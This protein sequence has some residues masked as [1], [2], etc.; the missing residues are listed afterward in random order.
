M[1]NYCGECEEN[2]VMK[3]FKA[4]E[5]YEDFLSGG[6]KV[7]LRISKA[8]STNKKLIIADEPT[9]NLD[10]KS[11]KILEARL[12]KMGGQ[13]AKKILIII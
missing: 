9:A 13:K 6:E 12:H 10:S 11:I 4:P 2:K 7:K 3:L 5:K 8:L 1:D